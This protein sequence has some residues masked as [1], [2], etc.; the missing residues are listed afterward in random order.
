[1]KPMLVSVA[2]RLGRGMSV[3]L[4]V[5]REIFDESAYA[6]FLVRSHSTS[7]KTA[8]AAFLEEHT[9][10]QARRHRCC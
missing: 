2:H 10:A 1:M 4:A 6:R 5:L 8:Y 3:L 9:S 7:S